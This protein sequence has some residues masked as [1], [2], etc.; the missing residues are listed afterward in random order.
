MFWLLITATLLTSTLG[1]TETANI[2]KAGG[3]L[4]AAMVGID[5]VSSNIL[6]ESDTGLRGQILDPYL[7]DSDEEDEEDETIKDYVSVRKL[8]RCLPEI[9]IEV[10]R[11]YDKFRCYAASALSFETERDSSATDATGEFSFK[12]N[13][14]Y[15]NTSSS[16]VD[17]FKNFFDS[18]EG[19]AVIVTAECITHLVKITPFTPPL[20]TTAFLNALQ[21]L[22]RSVKDSN[23]DISEQ[24]GE[25]IRSFGTHF[26]RKTL[27]GSRAIFG[28]LFENRTSSYLDELARRRCVM[29]SAHNVLRSAKDLNQFDT[30]VSE[31]CGSKD[32]DSWVSL[33][34]SA[35][36]TSFGDWDS[37]ARKSPRPIRFVLEK[38]SSLIEEIFYADKNTFSASQDGG[39]VTVNATALLPY[40]DK[41]FAQYSRTVIN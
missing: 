31:K 38:I 27:M 34:G 22:D 13:A 15:G 11:N 26:S 36:L 41:Q 21:K 35:P 28:K 8:S 14:G 1:Q 39:E 33:V 16:T 29:D 20:Y 5:P 23:H 10:I 3:Y 4:N 19:E 25:F 24:F 6:E 30:I 37:A 32:Q 7:L 9:K 40:F 2:N 12:E 17:T 18:T